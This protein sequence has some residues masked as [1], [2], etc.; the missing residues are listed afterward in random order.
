ML[1]YWIVVYFKA[2]FLK[3]LNGYFNYKYTKHITKFM[4][5]IDSTMK[6]SWETLLVST[7]TNIDVA[8][9][10]LLT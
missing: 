10:R 9:S 3:Y 2:P 8:T 7:S 4:A 1:S 5:K 6:H